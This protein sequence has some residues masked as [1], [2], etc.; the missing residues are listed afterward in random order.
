MDQFRAMHE[1]MQKYP[2]L[3]PQEEEEERGRGGVSRSLTG[4]SCLR[5][6]C[7]QR[8]GGVELMMAGALGSS[9]LQSPD[10]R[11][12]ESVFSLRSVHCNVQNKLLC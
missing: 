6:Q 8:G 5:G 10:K 12:Q 2:D 3:Y 7:N 11:L 9:D 1:C 4:S